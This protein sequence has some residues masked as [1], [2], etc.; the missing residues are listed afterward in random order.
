MNSYTMELYAKERYRELLREA[1]SERL[2]GTATVE[3]APARPW[4]ARLTLAVVRR[5]T[6][7]VGA[8]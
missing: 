7:V 3:R 5:L 8:A 2:I 4:R 1:A 6:R